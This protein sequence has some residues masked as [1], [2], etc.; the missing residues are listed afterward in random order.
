MAQGTDHGAETE[1]SPVSALARFAVRVATVATLEALL[2]AIIEV[3][4][5]AMVADSVHV[6]RIDRPHGRLRML[7]NA[8]Q[9][10]DWELESPADESYLVSDFPQPLCT[11]EQAKPWRGNVDDDTTAENDRPLL[12]S[13]GKAHAL[14]AP[15]ISSDEV[16]GSCSSPDSTPGR[17]PMAM[18]KSPWSSPGW[19]PRVWRGC[20]ATSDCGSWPTPT[21]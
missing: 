7:R 12:A 16:W 18:R 15:V 3:T 17:S 20:S 9:L 19:L 21:R 1:S 13:Q 11:T 14:S 5:G 4:T 2:D 10:A 6:G 8:G